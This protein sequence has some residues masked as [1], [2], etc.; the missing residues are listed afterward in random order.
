MHSLSLWR[1]Q[2][3]FSYTLS[4]DSI[5]FLHISLFHI[6]QNVKMGGIDTNIAAA[7]LAIS[8]V[9]FVTALGQLFQQYLAT[10]D[11]Y[12]RCQS[13]V[14]GGWAKRTRLRW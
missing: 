13:S 14:M 7:A 11:G 5:A 3:L 12:R 8:L 2:L 9:A 10:A 4:S 6:L 1:E